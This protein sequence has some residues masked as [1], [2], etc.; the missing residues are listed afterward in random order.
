MEEEKYIEQKVGKRNPFRVPEGYFEDFHAQLMQQISEQK[1]PEQKP[2]AK[3]VW[4]RK[5]MYYAAACACALFISAT[6]WLLTSK[7]DTNVSAP[8][9]L[10][11]QQDVHEEEFD[12]AAD[13]M[14]LDN[15]EIYALLS[16]N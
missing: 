4:M 16:E 7:P 5:P 2:R 3:S 9:Q 10:A 6:A 12:E 13:Y 15:H 14:M 11:S 8:T 1:R